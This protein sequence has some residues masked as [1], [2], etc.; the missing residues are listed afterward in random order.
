M[1]EIRDRIES[2]IKDLERRDADLKKRLEAQT[3]ELGK[4]KTAV[5]ARIDKAFANSNTS[6][7]KENVDKAITDAFA[8][9]WKPQAPMR[10]FKELREWVINLL[11]VNAGK[12]YVIRQVTAEMPITLVKQ[13]DSNDIDQV[14]RNML[15]QPSSDFDVVELPADCAHVEFLVENETISKGGY[16]RYKKSGKVP[17]LTSNRAKPNREYWEDMAVGHGN[18]DNVRVIGE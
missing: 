1:G 11:N 18:P 5:M 10:S 15:T 4:V 13:Y 3:V 2:V 9:Y 7:L 8:N 6:N 17:F 16:T 12:I 14:L